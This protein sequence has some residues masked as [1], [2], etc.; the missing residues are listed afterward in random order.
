[1]ACFAGPARHEGNGASR[2]PALAA[3]EFSAP[4]AAASADATA[5][6]ERRLSALAG[7][8]LRVVISAPTGRPARRCFPAGVIAMRIRRPAGGFAKTGLLNR[9]PRARDEMAGLHMAPRAVRLLYYGRVCWRGFCCAGGAGSP[10]P[11]LHSGPI[12]W[13]VLSN[14]AGA[15]QGRQSVAIFRLTSA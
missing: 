8:A 4:V 9:A 3:V 2:S 10:S 11:F 15:A 12:G 14:E 6:S 7:E 13:V 5:N 1:M